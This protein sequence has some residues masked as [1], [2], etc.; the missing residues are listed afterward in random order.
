ML[1]TTPTLLKGT[2]TIPGVATANN[3]TIYVYKTLNS[4]SKSVF[5][6]YTGYQNAP[7][8]K[9]A[10]TLIAAATRGGYAKGR[11]RGRHWRRLF[12]GR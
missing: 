11:L 6:V 5:T 12:R 4:S 8:S 3:D 10:N 7:T 1:S 2:A 9:G